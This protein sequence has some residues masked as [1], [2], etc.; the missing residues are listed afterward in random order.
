M[1][2]YLATIKPMGQ[3]I[4]VRLYR[5]LY[6]IVLPASL[7]RLDPDP[8]PGEGVS[9]YLLQSGHYAASTGQVK[10][11]AF[12]PAARDYK[13]S[14]FRVQG[15][16]EHQIWSLGDKYVAQPQG[17]QL[18]AYAELSVALIIGVGLRIEPKEPPPRHANIINW[19]REKDKMMSRAQELA[20]E[21]ILRLR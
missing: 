10:P 21:A 2:V 3:N 4:L 8:A 16:I 6:Q 11:R 9:R 19:P 7:L 18:R 1:L 20:A 12:H 14:V 13:T 5:W 17:K 15:L